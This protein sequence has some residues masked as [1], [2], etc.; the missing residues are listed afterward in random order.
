MLRFGGVCAFG[1]ICSWHNFRLYTAG[2]ACNIVTG[3]CAFWLCLVPFQKKV[4]E[5]FY[6]NRCTYGTKIFPRSFKEN[7]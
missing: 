4:K 1:G 2:V 6:E 5:R 7:F 3:M